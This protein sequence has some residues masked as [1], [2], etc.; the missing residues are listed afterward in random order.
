MTPSKQ[1]SVC[2]ICGK[3]FHRLGIARHR[4]SHKGKIFWRLESYEGDKLIRTDD[5]RSKETAKLYGATM[6]RSVGYFTKQ[7]IKPLPLPSPHA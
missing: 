3:S 7:I 6:A 1:P 4:A 2:H 5:F